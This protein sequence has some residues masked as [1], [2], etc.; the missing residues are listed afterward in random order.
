MFE[1]EAHESH[2]SC[3][4]SSKPP[5]SSCCVVK[6]LFLTLNNSSIS[7]KNLIFSR[8]YE[9]SKRFSLLSV[10][11]SI[12]CVHLFLHHHPL[13]C[14]IWNDLSIRVEGEWNLNSN[15]VSLVYT[16]WNLKL[17]LSFLYFI[18]ILCYQTFRK[19]NSHSVR[20]HVCCDCQDGHRDFNGSTYYWRQ[21]HAIGG[22][23]TS[24]ATPH[25]RPLTP[26]YQNMGTF[27]E[28]KGVPLQQNYLA[29]SA[30]H[31][32]SLPVAQPAQKPAAAPVAPVVKPTPVVQSAPANAPSQAE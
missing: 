9:I 18:H 5:T 7:M 15:S 23:A 3:A 19:N 12:A 17:C 26:N 28:R 14:K 30:P 13:V 24:N 1:S 27:D 29:P 10:V 22:S 16:T 6:R 25:P 11:Y 32:P 31:R 4:A 2:S 21:S 20:S 8:S